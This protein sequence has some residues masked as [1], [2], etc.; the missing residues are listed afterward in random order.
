M[1]DDL[2]Q[3]A[4]K[5][6]EARITATKQDFASIRTGRANPA[7]LDRIHVEYYGT[8]TPIQQMASVSVPEPRLLVIQ[9]WDKSSMKDIEKAILQSDLGL[10]PSND[11][12]VIR[13]QLPQLTEERRKDLVR[14]VRKGAEDHRIAV[15]NIRREVNDD[16]KEL[17]KASEISEDEARRAQARAQEMT[18]KAIAQIDSLL[19]AKES[20]IM[21]V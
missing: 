7:L 20:E 14:V 8:Q 10:T 2:L 15:R 11:G 17:E 21:E 16:L 12:S 6:M 13:I 4:S 19:Q 3:D 5:R 9:P 18:D 1:I